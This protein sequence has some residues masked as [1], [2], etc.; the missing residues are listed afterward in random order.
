MGSVLKAVYPQ[1]LAEIKSSYNGTI[2]VSKWLGQVRI[3][4]GGLLQSGSIINNIWKKP[5]KKI[6]KH[7]KNP[8]SVLILGFAGGTLAHLVS[9]KWPQ[10][11][12]TGVEIDPQMIKVA[13]KYFKLEKIPSLNLVNTDAQK[14]VKKSSKH[15]LIFVDLY[16]GKSLPKFVY[17]KTFIKNL[18]KILNKK[19][20]IVFNHLFYNEFKTQAERFVKT[21]DKNFSKITLVR[22]LCNLVII[23]QP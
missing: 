1:T 20:L 19:G 14:F 2:K 18:K 7:H 16:Y 12:I 21:L 6:F 10:A 3:E 5:L 8:K 11:K 22:P 9:K 23:C 13:K 17:K 15:D 4:A